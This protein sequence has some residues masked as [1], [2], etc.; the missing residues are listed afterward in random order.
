MEPFD[1][2]FRPLLAGRETFSISTTQLV[3]RQSL[4]VSEY[5]SSMGVPM[6][7]TL[8]PIRNKLIQEV[9]SGLPS[10][11]DGEIIATSNS[12]QEST[13]A[14]MRA[15]AEI[16]WEYHIFDYVDTSKSAIA[17]YSSRMS[18]LRELFEL[19]HFPEQCP[20]S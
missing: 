10:L 15:D 19:G 11:L 17:P 7:R 2:E 12:F 18:Q 20:D 8:K 16:P 9:L 1:R 6:S 14:V 4:T 3:Q 5:S 13:T